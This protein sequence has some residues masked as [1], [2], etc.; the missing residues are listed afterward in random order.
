MDALALSF[1]LKTVVR[2]RLL[3]VA[4]IDLT[5]LPLPAA[6]Q[7]IYSTDYTFSTL[8]GA[9]RAGSADRVGTDAQFDSPFGVAV[10]SAGNVYVADSGNHTIPESDLGRSGDNPGRTGGQSWQRGWDGRRR[11]V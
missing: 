1:R 5:M 3:S 4:F 9:A 2:N 8:A 6:A 11:A 10:D 7:S